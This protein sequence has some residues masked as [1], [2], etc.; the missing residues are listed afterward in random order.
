MAAAGGR[1]P[2]RRRRC[3]PPP[4]WRPGCVARAGRPWATGSRWAG[5]GWPCGGIEEGGRGGRGRR[6]RAE[7][8]GRGAGF[9]LQEGPEALRALA[10]VPALSSH[11][12]LGTTMPKTELERRFAKAVWL[13]RNGPPK[14]E[15]S[16]D[17]KLQF[18]GYFKQATE[19]D[20]SAPQPWAGAGTASCASAPASVLVRRIDRSRRCRD[21]SLSGCCRCRRRRPPL[22]GGPS[23]CTSRRAPSGRRGTSS[24]A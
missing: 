23:Q 24:R 12:P 10:P 5:A 14:A 11:A 22:L 19:G 6:R 15:T 9:C 16:N 1:P 13:I 4:V 21:Q 18:Y 7:C 8:D 3:P 2:R 20:C 17:E